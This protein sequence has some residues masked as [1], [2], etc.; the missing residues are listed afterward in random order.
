MR[1][2][3]QRHIHGNQ[4]GPVK[5]AIDVHEI[6]ERP[7]H[8]DRSRQ[9]N[10][11]QHDLR[12]DQRFANQPRTTPAA[13]SAGSERVGAAGVERRE[14]AEKQPAEKRCR[15]RKTQHPAIQNGIRLCCQGS[16]LKPGGDGRGPEG[17]EESGDGGR[18]REQHAFGQQLLREPAP[19]WLSGRTVWKARW[20]GPR[21]APSTGSRRWCKRA[22]QFQ[23]A[24]DLFY[25]TGI[26]VSAVAFSLLGGPIFGTMIRYGKRREDPRKH[27]KERQELAH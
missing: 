24:R 25:G 6:D 23:L 22:A 27:A 26:G 20:H 9:K 19:G 4:T 5:P 15:N 11:S 10:H 18:Q 8:R 7:A 21:S 17:D 3:F 14:D 1:G 12:R 16:G 2:S 13:G